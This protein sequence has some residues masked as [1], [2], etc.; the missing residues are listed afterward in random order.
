MK[1]TTGMSE[2][3]FI[4]CIIM[5]IKKVGSYYLVILNIQISQYAV[6]LFCVYP[7]V[8]RRPGIGIHLEGTVHQPPISRQVRKELCRY[9]AL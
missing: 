5:K 4:L 3:K 2:C 9:I 7:A 8:N 1:S 6:C